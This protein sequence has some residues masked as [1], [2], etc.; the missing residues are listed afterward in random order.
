MKLKKYIFTFLLTA[1]I[2]LVLNISISCFAVDKGGCLICHRYPGLV[3]LEKT[4]E[5]KVLHI[6]EEKHLAS[7]HGKVDCRKC[8]S[9]VVEIPHTGNT[10]V[11]CTTTCH[12]DDKEKIMAMN[13][14]LS[15]YHKSEKFAITSLEDKSSCRVCHPLYP[16]SKNNKVR[17][18]PFINISS[19]ALFFF[20]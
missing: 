8:H 15:A 7:P 14:S 17:G 13:S 9:Q 5:F 1:I 4:G 3:R 10:N 16:H 18:I 12:F 2:Y 6:D 11:E 20:R 19:I